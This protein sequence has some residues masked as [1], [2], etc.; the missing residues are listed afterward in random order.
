MLRLLGILTGVDLAVK[1]PPFL[2]ELL[3][4]GNVLEGD[5]EMDEV[6]VEVL[7]TPELKGL[8]AALLDLSS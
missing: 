7:E 6:K 5:G 1:S 4:G 3:L 2:R 8:L